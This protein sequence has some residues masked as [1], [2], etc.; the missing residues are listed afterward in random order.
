M[1]LAA[2]FLQAT[3]GQLAASTVQPPLCCRPAPTMVARKRGSKDAAPV[4]GYLEGFAETFEL[5]KELGKG[6]N[7]IVRLG[8]HRQTGEWAGDEVG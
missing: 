2:F 1:A 5:G 3:A 7:G 8:R 4:L 6:G